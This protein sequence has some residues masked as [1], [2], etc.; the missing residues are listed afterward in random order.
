MFIKKGAILETDGTYAKVQSMYG[1]IYSDVLL[2]Y[3]YGTQS[4]VKPSESTLVLLFGSLGSNTNLFGTPYDVMT[5]S[6]LEEGETEIKNRVSSLGFKAGAEKNN[7]TGDVDCDKSIN[8]VSY[9][10][11][12]IKVVGSQQPTIANPAGGAIIDAESRVAIA[13]IITAL[14]NHGLIA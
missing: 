9:K 2:L 13:N 4:K 11:A 8:A 14:K 10:V 7:I 1:E 6:I 12:N 5:Q 3:P